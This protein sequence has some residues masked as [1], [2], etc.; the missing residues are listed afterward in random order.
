L[1]SFVFGGI[2]HERSIGAFIKQAPECQLISYQSVNSFQIRDS[3]ALSS[4][5]TFRR[6]LH[7]GRNDG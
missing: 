1:T 7:Y 5:Q 4:I 6:F 2:F 3:R